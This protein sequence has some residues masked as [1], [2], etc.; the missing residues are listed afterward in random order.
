M[1]RALFGEIDRLPILGKFD[2]YLIT[3]FRKRRLDR[4]SRAV[5]GAKELRSLRN[6]IVHLKPHRVKWEVDEEDGTAETI[7]TKSLRIASNPNFW[8]TNDAISAMRAVHDFLHYFF[9]VLCKYSGKRV[10]SMLFSEAKV[11]GEGEYFVPFLDKDVALALKKLGIAI[12]YIKF[13]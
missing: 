12:S 9:K 11:A 7:R 2:F 1:E 3:K 5:L 8:D 13:I 6:G 10:A 4:N